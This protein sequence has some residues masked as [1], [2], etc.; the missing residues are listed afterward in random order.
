MENPLVFRD[1]QGDSLLIQGAVFAAASLIWF[2]V[3]IPIAGVAFVIVGIGMI[4]SGRNLTVTA[5][6]TTRLLRLEYQSRFGRQV[7]TFSFDEIVDIRL[8]RS[9]GSSESDTGY[10]VIAVLT[11]GQ[12]I[13]FHSLFTTGGEDER[14]QVT[15]LRAFIFNK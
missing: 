4:V 3:N 7:K 5:D 9:S 11:D 14:H 6:R 10:R 2:L 1:R 12:K 8:E 13:P 15:T